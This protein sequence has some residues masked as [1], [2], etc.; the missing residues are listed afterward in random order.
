MGKSDNNINDI[1]KQ[2]TV[3]DFIHWGVKHFEDARLFYGHGSVNALDEAAAICITALH[4]PHDLPDACLDKKL[5]QE[6]RSK[7]CELFVRRIKERIPA[8]YLTHEA[9]FAGLPFYVDERV[10]IPRSPIA[11]LIEDGFEP[12]VQKEVRRILDMCTGSGCIAIAC[13]FA[14]PEAEVDAVDI[15]SNAIEVVNI[16]IARHNLEERVHAMQ[17]DLFE[18]VPADKYDIIVSNPPY[19]S[20]AEMAELPEEYQCEPSIGLESGIDGLDAVSRIL[21]DS[22]CYL[23]EGGILVVEVGYSEQALID[24][25]PD[26]PFLWLEFEYGGEGVFMLTYEQLQQYKDE[27]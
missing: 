22:V 18:Q 19:V 7:L 8:A 16:N 6:D 13:A 25:Y 26:V 20:T 3:R 2:E 4:L 15:S 21:R 1:L 12:W 10:L 17:S 23:N 11:E 27:F 9:W 14:F 24:R 5:A